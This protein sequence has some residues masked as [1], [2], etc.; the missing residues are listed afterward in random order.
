MKF[1]LKDLK[2]FCAV[3]LSALITALAI[4]AF[5]DSGDLFPGGFSGI[6]TLISRSIWQFAGIEVSFGVLY[7]LFNIPV[8]ILV[9]RFVGKKFALFSIIQY[10]MTSFFTTVLPTFPITEDLLLIAVF[11]GIISGLGVS[12]ALRV[13]A[14]AG[15]TDFLAIYFSS[16]YNTP[17]WNH[18]MVANTLLLI[19]VGFLFTWEQALYSIIYQ[20]CSMQV[21]GSL[22]NR[23]KLDSLF[24]ITKYPNEVSKAIHEKCRH[25]ITKVNAEGMYTHEGV[26][27]LYMT[28]SV[29][30]VDRVTAIIT[31]VDPKAFITINKTERII[32]NY[33]QEPME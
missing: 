15:G 10:S 25:G 14:C 29:Y 1:T 32:G 3:I 16:K 22:H 18:I 8:T 19:I 27:L 30:Q 24:I 11:G 4:R 12:V 21:V 13:N 17:T 9:F 26:S 2:T 23:Y 5:I 20:F 33:Y 28:V 7:L 6:A 31:K